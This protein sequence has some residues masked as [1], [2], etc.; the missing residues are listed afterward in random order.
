MVTEVIEP[1]SAAAVEALMRYDGQGE[2]LV[3]AYLPTTA[4]RN[5][6]SLHNTFQDLAKG[7]A[8]GLEDK[9][10]RAL[11]DTERWVAQIR[12]VDGQGLALFA[13]PG[14]DWR[15]VFSLPEPV[16]PRLGLDRNMFLIAALLRLLDRRRSGAAM[17]VGRRLARVFRAEAGRLREVTAVESDV[18]Q[19]VREGGWRMYE[20]KRIDHHILDHLH[21]HLKAAVARLAAVLE[22]QPADWVVI[23]GSDEPRALI[24]RW[25]PPAV[26]DRLIGFVDLP[27]EAT[28]EVF[29][30]RCRAIEGVRKLEEEALLVAAALNRR[31]QGT[32]AVG[33]RA[34]A[35]AVVRGAV[36][37]LLVDA[38]FA[39]P[40]VVCTACGMALPEEAAFQD[41]RCPNCREKT[42][43][44]CQ[45]LA[46]WLIHQTV[47]RQ[48]RV[49]FIQEHPRF[50]AEAGE[51]AALL[52]YPA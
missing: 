12:A 10:A 39:G 36:D 26:R 50:R 52:R 3:S 38:S 2:W 41:A 23:G 31:H 49:A 17:L 40:G 27:V 16:A 37:T 42:L 45:D 19:D 8:A 30:Q 1:L 5:P 43:E 4:D 6:L 7:K 11:A 34:V 46:E 9:A 15:A 47:T 48:G 44:S 51:V 14:R 33:L 25:L 18:P 32:A 22:E 28:P 29:E 35:A 13:C 21:R 20:E 24:G